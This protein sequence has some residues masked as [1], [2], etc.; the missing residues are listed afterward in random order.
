MT[1][2]PSSLVSWASKMGRAQRPART[3]VILSHCYLSFAT[4][5]RLEGLRDAWL[6]LRDA[7]LG[8]VTPGSV[9]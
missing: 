1:M 6:G 5:N 9:T 7:W 4:A 8:D 3:G 2:Y